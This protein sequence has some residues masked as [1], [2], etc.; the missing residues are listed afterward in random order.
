MALFSQIKSNPLSI[1]SLAIAPGTSVYLGHTPILCT[2]NKLQYS[3][4]WNAFQL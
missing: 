3:A 1:K 2:N 4:V